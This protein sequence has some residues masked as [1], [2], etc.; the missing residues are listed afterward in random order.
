M[1]ISLVVVALLL[2]VALAAVQADVQKATCTVT[3]KSV[4][5]TKTTPQIKVNGFTYYFADKVGK[6]KFV[7]NPEKYLKEIVCPV[8]DEQVKVA[9]G[10]PSAMYKG[11]LYLF[12][13]RKCQTAFNKDP[14]KYAKSAAKTSA[15]L[16]G[17][18]YCPMHNEVV[19]KTAGKCSICGMNLI[20]VEK[21]NAPGHDGHKH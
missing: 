20:P 14:E 4:T 18:Y 15:R 13:C 8:L 3:G 9:A 1:R 6:D 17:N 7:K 19:S 11:N 10:M 16:Y 21:P 2:A 5:V 12:C